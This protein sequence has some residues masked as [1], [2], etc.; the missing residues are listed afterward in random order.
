MQTYYYPKTGTSYMIL[1]GPKMKDPTT[2]EWKDA[3]LYTDGKHTYC[4][5]R[6]DFMNK[7][8]PS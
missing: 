2:G 5:E 6:E 3:I 4:R 7:F 8:K 1:G